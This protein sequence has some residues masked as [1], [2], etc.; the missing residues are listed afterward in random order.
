MHHHPC[1]PNGRCGSRVL[2]CDRWGQRRTTGTTVTHRNWE[3]R[4]RTKIR[5]TIAFLFQHIGFLLW[6]NPTSSRVITFQVGMRSVMLDRLSEHP[7]GQSW[8]TMPLYISCTHTVLTLPSFPYLAH[9]TL[10]MILACGPRVCEPVRLKQ[11]LGPWKPLVSEPQ[12]WCRGRLS[13][14]ALALMKIQGEIKET[15]GCMLINMHTQSQQC[16]FVSISRPF[17]SPV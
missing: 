3:Q 14:R 2:E 8:K 11:R 13:F 7:A 12:T 6:A 9:R 15:H 1:F 16:K 5:S 4:K 10:G 17:F